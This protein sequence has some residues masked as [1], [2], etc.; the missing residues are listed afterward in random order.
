LASEVLTLPCYPEMSDKE[1]D[2]VI[3]A[4][5]GWKA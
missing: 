1:V 2:Q 3:S 5:N 4:I